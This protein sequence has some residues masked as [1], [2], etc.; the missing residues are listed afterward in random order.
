MSRSLDDTIRANYEAIGELVVGWARV[1]PADDHE[2]AQLLEALPHSSVPD[3]LNVIG[4]NL[5]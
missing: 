4:A 3:A 1:D 2:V 5:R